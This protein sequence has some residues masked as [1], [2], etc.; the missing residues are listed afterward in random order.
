MAQQ[1]L[2]YLNDLSGEKIA[3]TWLRT[4]IQNRSI[5]KLE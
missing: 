4:K 2:K 1:L 3:K 5:I